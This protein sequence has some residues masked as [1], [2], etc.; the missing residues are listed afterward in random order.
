MCR[1]VAYLGRPIQLAHV[2]YE[3]DSSLVTQTYRPQMLANLNLAGFGMAVWNGTGPRPEEPL[4]YRTTKLPAFDPNLRNLSWKL[5]ATCLLAH[6]RGVTMGRA[7]DV[8]EQNVHPFRFPGF[9]IALAHNGHLR[10]FRRMRFDLVE[11]IRPEIASSIGGTTDSEW[12]SAL[13]LSQLEGPG[14]PEAGELVAAIVKAL[15]VLREVRAR[16]GIATSSPV[17]LFL[18]TGQCLVATRFTFDYGWY[19]ADDPLLEVDLPYASLW[20]TAGE[21]YAERDGEWEMVGDGPAESFLIGSEP[22]T[23]NTSTWLEMPEYAL[24]S[25]SLRDGIVETEWH[26]VDV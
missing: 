23:K 24:L 26:D 14:A 2:L 6:V 4:V 22:L 7:D 1:V 8:S 21:R 20:Y 16:H 3:T 19:P 15:R 13:V 17:N 5:E 18:S 9:G 12:L 10:E 25:A 11:H